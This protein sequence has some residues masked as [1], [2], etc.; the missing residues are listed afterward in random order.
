MP[1]RAVRAGFTGTS[2]RCRQRARANLP[3]RQ[4][5]L[6]PVLGQ[7]SLSRQPPSLQR[8]QTR[9]GPSGA[10]GA[11]SL[12]GFTLGAGHVHTNLFLSGQASA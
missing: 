8:E 11:A 5:A 10:E 7:A 6:A 9:M 2:G 3:L 4:A 12:Q 1:A